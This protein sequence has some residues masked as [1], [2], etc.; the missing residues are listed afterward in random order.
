MGMKLTYIS[1]RCP[2]CR[3]HKTVRH[4]FTGKVKTCPHCHGAGTVAKKVSK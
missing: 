3:G 1:V 2:V 4:Y